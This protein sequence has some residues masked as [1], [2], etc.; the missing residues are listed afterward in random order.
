MVVWVGLFFA[1]GALTDAARDY[2]DAVAS[3]DFPGEEHA[4]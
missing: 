1:G 2:R 3:G 4:Y